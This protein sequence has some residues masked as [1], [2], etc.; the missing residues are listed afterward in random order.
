MVRVKPRGVPLSRDPARIAQLERLTTSSAKKP[1]NR[2][3]PA[4]NGNRDSPPPGLVVRAIPRG[5][6]PTRMQYKYEITNPAL[7]RFAS[8]Y[9][10]KKSWQRISSLAKAWELYDAW[11]AQTARSA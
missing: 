10:A 4:P 7:R 6:D 1:R 2:E 8:D 3:A 9:I 11:R 5:D